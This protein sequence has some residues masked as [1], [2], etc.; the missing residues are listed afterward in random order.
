MK[1]F[2]ERVLARVRERLEAG[3][4]EHGSLAEKDYDWDKEASEELLDA[5]VYL[6]AK[7]E[8]RN[9][10]PVDPCEYLYAVKTALSGAGFVNL[11]RT[12]GALLCHADDLH[13]P[14]LKKACE[15]AGVEWP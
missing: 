15:L 12:R 9:G 3:A 11:K 4:A 5:I 8:K 1:P 6:A 14:T 7:L 2:E 13:L 10:P